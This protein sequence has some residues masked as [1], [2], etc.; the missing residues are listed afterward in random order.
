VSQQ[1]ET[2]SAREETLS[3][4]ERVSWI[5]FAATGLALPFF[6][7]PPIR[8]WGKP[9]DLA[10]ILAGAFV[11]SSLPSLRALA[12]LRRTQLF[13][14]AVLLVPLLA[15]VPPR[16][17][18]FSPR[19]FA[20]TYAHWLLVTGF[21]LCSLTLAPAEKNVRALLRANVVLAVLI[22]AFAF[23]QSFGWPRH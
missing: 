20:L 10:T 21:F 6:A 17:P 19:Q 2:G 11:L 15:L 18:F 13:L 3:L 1:A 4:R 7:F 5:L 9:V 12:A 16:P 8:L 23:Y 14:A 22:A